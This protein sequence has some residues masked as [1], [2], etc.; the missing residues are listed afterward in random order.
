MDFDLNESQA[1]LQDSVRK[2]LTAKYGFE[3]RK[4][5]MASETGWSREL[6]AQ[7]ADL[8]L[9]GLPFSEEDGGF[10]G[11]PE[12]T[13]LVAEQMGRHITLEPWFSTVVLGGGLL[14]HGADAALRGELVPAIA[15]GEAL[16][17]LA[18]VERQ[19]RY[20]LFDVTTTAK[21]D[22]TG[23]VITGRKGMVLHGDTADWF[24]VSARVSGGQR[25]KGGIG[26]FLV[27]AK[28]PGVEVRGFRTVDGGR[29]AEVDFTNARSHAVLGAPEGGLPILDRVVDEAI[30]A[31]AAE[32]VGAM[33]V[34]HNMTLDYM[35]TR[36]QFGKVIGTFQALQHRA[37]DMLVALE[38]SRSMAFFATM[39]AQG[40]NAVER[41]NNMHAVKAQ[42][43]R[44]QRFV[45]QQS[46]QLHG[47]IAMTME[48]GAGHYFKRLTVNEAMFG[49][50]DHHLR[51]LADAGGLIQAA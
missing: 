8:G 23:Y 3:N 46:I 41:R 20:D 43:G 49:D 29:A 10:G 24:V 31:L 28:T 1:L 9:L 18:Q 22:G 44:S 4:A 7:Y 33:E 47:G 25:D 50:T 37:A 51:A 12:E 11:G 6:W 16:M 21:K 27:S 5:Y 48:Y 39:A 34:V 13:M 45:G 14:R 30:A 40:D 2:S 17:A 35:K 36:Q 19:S 15:S 26:L 32:A 38:Q 42:I